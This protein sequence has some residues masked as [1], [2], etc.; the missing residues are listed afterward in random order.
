MTLPSSSD[1]AAA[2]SPSLSDAVVHYRASGPGLTENNV[3]YMIKQVYQSL[4]R[5]L[6]Q[7]MAPLG[8][9][10]MQ[11]RP[12]ACLAKG[13][14]STSVELARILAVD[15]GAMTRTLD[16]LEAKGLLVRT[17]SKEDRRVVDIV[18]TEEGQRTAK[19]IPARIARALNHYLRGFSADEVDMLAHFLQR[20][21]A[22]GSISP[23][24]AA[25]GKA[26]DT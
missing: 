15:S 6:D 17:R 20:M 3:G 12:V 21:L 11:W 7:D 5:V 4:N 10:A 9:T 24:N 13:H 25:T 1:A 18:L 22:N 14:A 19:E 23:P 8:L 2:T 16:R 26:P